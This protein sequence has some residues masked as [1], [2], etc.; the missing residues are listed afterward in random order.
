MDELFKLID[1]RIK[2]KEKDSV[3]VS[4]VPCVVID[5]LEEE[6]VRVKI[7]SNGAE[8]VLPN[9]SGSIL[10]TGERALVFYN[11]TIVDSNTAYV[12]ASINKSDKANLKNVSGEVFL[13]ALTNEKRD[14][15]TILFSNRA[16]GVLLCFNANIEG[17]TAIG[18][19]TISI[20]IDGVLYD[21]EPV[22][23]TI[24]NGYTHLSFS[25]PLNLESGEHKAVI[26]GMGEYATLNNIVAYVFGDIDVVCDSTD[27]NDY[28][29]Q[30]NEDESVYI[31][32]YIGS[33]KYIKTPIELDGYPVKTIGR[34]AFM[35]TNVRVVQIQEGVEEIE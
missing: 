17:D 34:K 35:G 8:Y 22:F 1:E 26:K 6:M 27:E 10:T 28:I 9:W 5:I 16:E 14:L 2:K 23:S 11:G 24:I 20:Y 15:A 13:G 19:G 31:I 18:N 33:K 25:L 3:F 12:G 29:W 21:Y 30:V 4:S 32:K 7:M